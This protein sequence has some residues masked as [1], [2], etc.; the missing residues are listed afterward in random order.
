MYRL[1]MRELLILSKRLRGNY[2]AV[3]LIACL[4]DCREAS[5]LEVDRIDKCGR[6]GSRS[7]I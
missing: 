6:K 4:R 5:V 1:G 3:K 2:S 7:L